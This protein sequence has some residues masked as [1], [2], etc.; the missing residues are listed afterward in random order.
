MWGRRRE[1][2]EGLMM[3]DHKRNINPTSAMKEREGIKYFQ[4]IQHG[5]GSRRKRERERER[6]KRE[7]GYSVW[8]LQIAQELMRAKQQMKKKRRKKRKRCTCYYN[9]D[10]GGV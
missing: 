3:D 4:T 1:K 2:K 5:N 7:K 9:D 8:L 10:G 6:I